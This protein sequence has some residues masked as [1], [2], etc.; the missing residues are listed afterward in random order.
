MNNTWKLKFAAFIHSTS[1]FYK[2]LYFTVLALTIGAGLLSLFSLI[3][4]I[5]KVIYIF[6]TNP[7]STFIMAVFFIVFPVLAFMLDKSFA[8]MMNEK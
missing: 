1:V 4:F 5:N 7:T 6:R 3:N 8:T 2:R